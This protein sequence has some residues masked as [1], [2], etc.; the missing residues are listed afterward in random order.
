MHDN[1]RMIHSLYTH[2]ILRYVYLNIVDIPLHN[3]DGLFVCMGKIKN[4]IIRDE[5]S[6]DS[7]TA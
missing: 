7:G 1:R 2:Y 6:V 3:T 5:K 4:I